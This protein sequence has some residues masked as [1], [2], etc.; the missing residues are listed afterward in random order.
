ML[1]ISIF[2]SYILS[3]GYSMKSKLLICLM[4][5]ISIQSRTTGLELAA[6]AIV[7][8]KILSTK[9]VRTMGAVA[10]GYFLNTAAG[11][12]IVAKF[13]DLMLRKIFAKHVSNKFQLNQSSSNILSRFKGST[14]INYFSKTSSSLASM[15]EKIGSLNPFRNAGSKM[16]LFYSSEHGAASYE[17]SSTIKN[18][19]ERFRNASGSASTE[20]VGVTNVM[21]Q[22]A[23][24]FCPKIENNFY[25]GGYWKGFAQG[26]FAAWFM[27]WYLNSERKDK[28]E[29]SLLVSD[30]KKQLSDHEFLKNDPF[31]RLDLAS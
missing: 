17:S 10:T 13:K 12:L 18:V 30:D 26:S 8:G 1:Q 22:Q 15:K 27:A 29:E 19:F 2:K 16:N 3:F 23:R 14:D 4:L 11:K 9:T 6:G 31:T 7:A 24:G 20:T 25:T 28:K 5:F 21:A